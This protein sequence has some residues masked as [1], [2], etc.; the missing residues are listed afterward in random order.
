M[1]IIDV[2]K[3][4]YNVFHNAGKIYDAITDL[5]SNFRFNTPYERSF[6]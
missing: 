5:I 6:W 1:T 2:N 4:T 3:L